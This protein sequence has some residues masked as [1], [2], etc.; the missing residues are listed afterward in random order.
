M[1]KLQNYVYNELTQLV[2]AGTRVGLLC[3]VYFRAHNFHYIF[4]L[5]TLL[6]L[7]VVKLFSTS[8]HPANLS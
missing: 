1:H 5:F 7:A 4:A 2:L 8:F 6:S 3:F